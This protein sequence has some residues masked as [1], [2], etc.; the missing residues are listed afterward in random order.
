V[1]TKVVHVV[2]S[3]AGP[4]AAYRNPEL[5]WAHA[6]SMLGVDV[7]SCELRD[8]LPEVVVD[9]LESDFDDNDDTPK[10]VDAWSFDMGDLDDAPGK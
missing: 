8:T 2:W 3:P 10:V 9:D 7:S 1:A 5:A 6:R 4:V